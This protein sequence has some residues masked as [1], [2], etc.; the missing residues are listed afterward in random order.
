MADNANTF[1][2]LQST[3]KDEYAGAFKPK[4][5]GRMRKALKGISLSMHLASKDPKHYVQKQNM[6]IKTKKGVVV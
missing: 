6:D 5:F 3:L 1:K 4:R 2:S